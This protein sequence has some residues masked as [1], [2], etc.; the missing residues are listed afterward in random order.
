MHLIFSAGAPSQQDRLTAGNKWYASALTMAVQYA[1]IATRDG[2]LH[3]TGVGKLDV[4][5]FCCIWQ[6]LRAKYSLRPA[7][8]TK[9]EQE[10]CASMHTL[11]QHKVCYHAGSGTGRCMVPAWIWPHAYLCTDL[12]LL[13]LNMSIEV[14]RAC[15]MQEGVKLKRAFAADKIQACA[16]CKQHG[17]WARCKCELVFYCSTACQRTD[18]SRH[19]AACKCNIDECL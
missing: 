14:E 13:P 19:R 16:L 7:D 17:L 12:R 2:K 6:L 1:G 4:A 18:W 9:L 5:H 15:G 8:R 11:M 10:L 3:A